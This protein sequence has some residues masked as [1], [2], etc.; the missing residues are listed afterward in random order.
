MN[1]TELFTENGKSAGAFFCEKCRI[2]HPNKAQAAQCCA[3][4]ICECGAECE[5][6]HTLCPACTVRKR[7]ERE[8]ELFA[9]AEKVTEW[10][11][12][13]WSEG[14]GYNDGYFQ[15]LE[16]FEDW[17]ACEAEEDG[18]QPDRPEYVWT[19]EYRMFLQ[20]DYG[21]IIENATQDAYENWNDSEINGEGDLKA[22]IERFNA[23]NT[24]H[25]S[26]HPNMKR[27]LLLSEFLSARPE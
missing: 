3:P 22:A 2:I 17:M 23:A 1:A 8:T 27:A 5:R 26:W 16:D 12:A 15:N 10:S 6:Y 24:E 14:H 19:C 21:Q 11:G 9:K 18:S 7:R 25:I 4:R 13:I 20:L